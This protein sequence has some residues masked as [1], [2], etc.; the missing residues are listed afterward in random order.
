MTPATMR[1][2]TPFVVA[3]RLPCEARLV[4]RARLLRW[5]RPI[6]R[7]LSIGAPDRMD[8]MIGFAPSSPGDGLAYHAV[9]LTSAF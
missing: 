2:T 1:K 6:R 8:D 9:T 7:A 3:E 4:R 5:A